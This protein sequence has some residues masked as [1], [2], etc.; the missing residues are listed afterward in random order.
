MTNLSAR[1]LICLGVLAISMSLQA[2]DWPQ[3]RGPQSTGVSSETGLLKKW[4][5]AGPAV[6]WQVENAGVGFSS[7]A[8]KDGRVITQGDLDGVEH[9]IAYSEKDGKLLWAV[10]PESV[11]KALA[12]KV[13]GEFER[14]D[15]DQDGKLTELEAAAGLGQNFARFDGVEPGDKAEIAHAR[16]EVLMAALDKDADGTLT[17]V[18]LNAALRGVVEK[19]DD[20]EKGAEGLELAASRAQSLIKVADKDDDEQLSREEASGTLAERIF[21]RVDA[22]VAGTDKGDGQ[23]TTAELRTHFF[24]REPGRDGVLSRNELETYYLKNF[25]GRDGVLTKA[26][27]RRF[28]GGYRNGN[29]DGPRGTPTIDGDHV[30]VEGGRGDVTCLDA[31]TGKTVWTVSL[32]AK[33][34]GGIPG[35]G[36]CESPLVVDDLLIVT[37]GGNEGTIAALDKRTGEVAVERGFIYW[38]RPVNEM[39]RLRDGAAHARELGRGLVLSPVRARGSRTRRW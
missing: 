4:P 9:I 30:Y 7:L 13:D 36:Y 37:P 24:S 22:K 2:E 12:V 28:Y 11:G 16:V 25:P 1:L 17:Y 38:S 14:F 18:E 34:R 39:P 20:E 21:D 23:L 32:T 33:L 19:I 3:W 27:L 31:V 26:D 35:W 10:Q 6:A 15:K 8:V 5:A 29:G